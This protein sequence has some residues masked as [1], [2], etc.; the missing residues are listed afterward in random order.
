MRRRNYKSC[1]SI[2]KWGKGMAAIIVVV[3][4]LVIILPSA[5]QPNILKPIRISQTNFADTIRVKIID[6]AVIIPTEIN[7]KNKDLLFD[8]G[9]QGGVWIGSK[10]DWMT[11]LPNDSL[12][13][14]DINN[15]TQYM[16]QYE[17]PPIKI[18]STII[19]NYT[20]TVN[21][22][23][24]EHICGMFDGII[25]FNLITQGLS[26][27]IDTKDSLL[28]LTDRNDFFASE[29]KGQ[30]TVEYGIDNKPKPSFIA[31]FPFG[32]M[33][34]TFDSGYIGGWID[35]PQIWLDRWMKEQD[36]MKKIIDSYTVISDTTIN[37]IAG[38]L[39][40]SY[41]T[42]PYRQ[43][44]IPWARL[45]TLTI[46]DIWTYTD[47]QNFVVGSA[48]LE[49]ASLII[50]AQKKH[51]VFLPHNGKREIAIGNKG[52]RDFT[53]IPAPTDDTLGVLKAVVR[54][55]TKTYNE[56]IRTGDYLISIDGTPVTDMCSYMQL[57]RKDGPK[58][59]VFK[60]AS[61]DYKR[62]EK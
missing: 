16:A 5:T 53:V 23:L 22:K 45:G 28:I 56:G 20:M 34:L 59:F 52:D 36:W 13:I 47:C 26:M 31:E 11:L 35:L 48:I 7:G 18:G 44:H 58:V 38:A 6:G 57:K 61:G 17:L 4:I 25:G 12:M 33:V 32:G 27:K 3:S 60:T 62:L 21:E 54:K 46:S 39:G 15:N 51:L 37:T 2:S 30:P 55:E 40:T 9:S 24:D 1:N 8:S 41:D 50:D 10:E 29:E 14:R 19:E 42:T 43:L 49:H